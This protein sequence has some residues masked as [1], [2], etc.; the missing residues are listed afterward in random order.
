[1]E[2][3][4]KLKQLLSFQEKNLCNMLHR[5]N[6]IEAALRIIWPSNYYYFT[7]KSIPTSYIKFIF[8]KVIYVKKLNAS[9]GIQMA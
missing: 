5:P 1:M 7:Y 4:K 6:Q 3:V 2:K 9:D 8:S